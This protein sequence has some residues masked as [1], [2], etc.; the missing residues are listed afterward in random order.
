M[1]KLVHPLETSCSGLVFY[2]VFIKVCALIFLLFRNLVALRKH[3]LVNFHQEEYVEIIIPC[4]WLFYNVAL[5][6][7]FFFLSSFTYFSI[8]KYIYR[9]KISTRTAWLSLELCTGLLLSW[10]WTHL[11][12]FLCTSGKWISVRMILLGATCRQIGNLQITIECSRQIL[13]MSM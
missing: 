3:M 11:F 10:Y 12:Q 7:L 4:S 9:G 6:F 2:F 5:F 8:S 1:N 13:F